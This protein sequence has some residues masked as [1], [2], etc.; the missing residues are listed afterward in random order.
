[1]GFCRVRRVW[2]EIQK[3]PLL[4]GASLYHPLR[5]GD[6][7]LCNMTKENLLQLSSRVHKRDNTGGCSDSSV[8]VFLLRWVNVRQTKGN[9]IRNLLLMRS[10]FLSVIGK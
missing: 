4:R 6:G 2:R 8:A 5:S 9:W 7:D 1:M 10:Q 3:I